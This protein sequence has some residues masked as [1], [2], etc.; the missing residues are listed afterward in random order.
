MDVKKL[1]SELRWELQGIEQAIITLERLNRPSIG[2]AE[3]KPMP[4]MEVDWA[5]KLDDS[6]ECGGLSG[7]PGTS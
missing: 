5:W 1:V 3:V 7:L 6:S 2:I 4:V